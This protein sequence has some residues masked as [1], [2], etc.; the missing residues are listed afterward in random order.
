VPNPEYY[1]GVLTVRMSLDLV[2]L[3][4]RSKI[5][6]LRKLPE[7][8]ERVLPRKGLTGHSGTHDIEAW[9]ESGLDVFVRDEWIPSLQS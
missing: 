1:G 4:D 7:H 6:L 5:G 2:L 8:V 9:R 3:A